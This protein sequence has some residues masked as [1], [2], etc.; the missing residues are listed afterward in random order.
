LLLNLTGRS[1]SYMTTDRYVYPAIFDYADEG[2]AI[3][4]PDLPG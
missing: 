1:N 2:I 4:F 3:E